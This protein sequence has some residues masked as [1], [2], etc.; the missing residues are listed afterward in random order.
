MTRRSSLFLGI[1]FALLAFTTSFAGLSD[2]GLTWDEARYFESAHRI[3]EWTGRVVRG[4]DRIGALDREA[5]REAWDVDRYFNPHPPV[6]KEAMALTDA[7]IGDHFG[8]LTG[9]RTSSLLM[10][11]LLVGLVAGLTATLIRPASGAGAGLALLLMPRVLGHAHIAATDLPLTLF[12]FVATIGIFLFVR[13][14]S[15]KWLIAGAVALGLALGTKFTGFLAPVPVLAWLLFYGRDR[16]S[17]K[18]FLLWMGFAFVVAVAVNP[19]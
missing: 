19:A 7:V 8:P 9:F 4:P 3:Q 13:R 14:G 5:I 1:G 16:T 2:V 17:A 12:W 10:F 11:S 6:Y 18:A 15:R